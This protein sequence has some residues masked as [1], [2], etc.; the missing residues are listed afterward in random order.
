M[1]LLRAHL[2]PD[3]EE[4]AVVMALPAVVAGADRIVIGEQ[5]GVGGRLPPASS[6]SDTVAVPSE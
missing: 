6:S 3:E 1:P 4:D 5:Q 2:E